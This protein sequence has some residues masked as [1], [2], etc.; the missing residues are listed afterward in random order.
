M[1]SKY[2]KFLNS[3]V[4]EHRNPYRPISIKMLEE[5]MSLKFNLSP[6]YCKKIVAEWRKK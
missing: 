1:G 5:R 6:D 2:K 3:V 4:K